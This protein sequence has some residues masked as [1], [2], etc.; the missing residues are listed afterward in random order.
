MIQKSVVPGRR[1]IAGIC[2]M[3]GFVFF[4]GIFLLASYGAR[5][6]H[7]APVP[8]PEGY[9]KFNVSLKSVT[10]TL[11]N[12]GSGNLYYVIEMRNTGGYTATGV[13][14][15]DPIPGGTSYNNDAQVSQGP[16]PMFSNG[17]LSWVGDVGFDSTV[18]LSFSVSLSPAFSGTV[19]NQAVISQSQITESVVLSV[20]TIVTD[21][22]HLVIGKTAEP[23]VPG[24]GKPLTYTL[25]VTNT[26][27]TA[28]N[29]PITVTDYVPA[30][31]TLNFVGPDGT[32]SPSEDMV[33]W[34]RQVSLDTGQATTFTFGVEV[35]GVPAGTAIVND[36]YEVVGEGGLLGIGE[37]V[38][39]TVT[40]P[41][42]ILS[43]VTYPDP[44]GSNGEF[45]YTLTVL[46][47]GSLATDLVVRDEVPAGVTYVR[48]GSHSNG[49]VTWNY[50]RLDNG[51]QAKFSFTVYVGDVAD[52][53]VVNDTYS[54]CS[55][56]GVCKDG[57]PLVS[58]I[59][60]P[61]FAA[62]AH[63]DPIAKKP[64]GG[65]GPVTPTLIV[66]NIGAGSALDA[67][68]YLEFGRISVS[69]NDLVADP[70]MG[71]FRDGPDCGSHCVSYFWDGDLSAGSTVTFTTIEGQSTIGG[72]EGTPYTATVV[73]TDTLGAFTTEPVTATAIGLVT[74]KANLVPTKSAP[75]VIGRGQVLTY[76]I[77]VW[78][79]GLTTDDFSDYPWLVE[80]VPLSTSLLNVSHG[81]TV[82]DIDGRE[83]IS[84]TLPA[85]STGE[86][87]FREF[88]VIV[89]D[90]LI[91]GTKLINDEYHTYWY[92]LEDSEVLSNTGETFTTTVK[93]VGLIDS[94]KVV[95]P[96]VALPGPGNLLTH[97][98]HVVNTSPNP[99]DNVSVY[100]MLPWQHTT[101][102]RDAAASAGQVISDIVSVT[103]NGNLAPYS[104]EVVTFTVLVDAH[105]EGPVTN[106]ASIS[107]TSLLDNVIVKSVAYITD[108]PVFAI[109]KFTDPTSA[110]F[111]QE[112][113][114]TI[115]VT[116]LG[117][118][119]TELSVYDTLPSNVQYVSGSATAGGQLVG[120]Q[121]RW[122]IPVLE[123]GK[124]RLLSF[125]VVPLTGLLIVNAD[126]GVSSVEGVSA[127]GEP[128]YTPIIPKGIIFLPF[129][130]RN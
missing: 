8:P 94:F 83:V 15:T 6:A 103:W 81:G 17:I 112:L 71:S 127:S 55:A 126:Y 40:D 69:L 67:S 104:A 4:A 36:T 1:I 34:T 22:P 90:N 5:E 125:R 57:L 123:P 10:P 56:E 63:L 72:G 70:P 110:K 32:A 53:P 46:N 128:V 102:Q 39:V 52:I 62:Q 42:F 60:G 119:A 76:T 14:L 37:L 27:Q 111:G 77:G 98:I 80:T 2:T 105:Y 68:A 114:Y 121:V 24:P 124:T 96:T 109:S 51:E 20:E 129:I 18:V 38:S 74:H 11:V 88:S 28:S 95:T 130:V 116:N 97:Q 82:A 16:A 61:V 118:Q 13:Q 41:D 54:V 122:S 31:T 26:G 106:T 79:S 108:K 107:H 78:N 66:E 93:E 65:T 23:T 86:T 115:K 59:Q 89:D 117:Q 21:D 25:V 75:K 48:G 85:L 12:V 84:W 43:K 58:L 29:L 3:V 113:L 7:A 30:D 9:P 49:V 19:N 101:Y 45:T 120:N 100:D 64:G 73:V 33:T 47:K 99:L 92:E 44:P 50:P 91:S 87:L 35:D